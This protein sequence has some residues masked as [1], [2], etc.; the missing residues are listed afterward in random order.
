[1]PVLVEDSADDAESA[2]DSWHVVAEVARTRQARIPWEVKPVGTGEVS[3]A[4]SASAHPFTALV[5]HAQ[6]EVCIR[7]FFP[8]AGS[9]QL[10][11]PGAFATLFPAVFHDSSLAWEH[12][13]PRNGRFVNPQ[14]SGKIRA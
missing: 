3:F 14:L 10:V 5:N 11:I 2:P 7:I 6:A 13:I 8:E 9:A 4:V 12:T 1:M